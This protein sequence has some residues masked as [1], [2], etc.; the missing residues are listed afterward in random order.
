MKA[1]MEASI[2][3]MEARNFIVEASTEVG[4]TEASVKAS[5]KVT[6][7]E[8]STEAFTEVNFFHGSF[9]G[10]KLAST[11]AF[12]DVNVLLP[13]LSNWSKFASTKGF[14]EDST[15]AFMEAF[16]EVNCFHRSFRGSKFTSTEAFA[17]AFTEPNPIPN[18]NP[19]P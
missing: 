11:E 4:S 15:E 17:G 16:V 7:K 14:K 18:P 9:R 13:K 3:S 1:S 12:T 10:R 2:A 6:S 19:D 5:T 8:T